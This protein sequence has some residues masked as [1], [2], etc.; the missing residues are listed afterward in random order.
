MYPETDMKSW[1]DEAVTEAEKGLSEGGIPIGNL[2]SD[3]FIL[4]RFHFLLVNLVHTTYVVAH[5]L[6]FAIML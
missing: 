1:L 3:Y 6:I 4:K 2:F 5:S